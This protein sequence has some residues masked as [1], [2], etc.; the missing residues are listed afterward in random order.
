MLKIGRAHIWGEPGIRP[1]DR[2]P[3]LV[4]RSWIRPWI[5]PWIRL[6]IR[7]GETLQEQLLLRGTSREWRAGAAGQG[8]QDSC[9]G[10]DPASDPEDPMGTQDV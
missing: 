2:G 10:A 4:T 7:Q 9:Q 8:H 6:W 5:R 1:H 3:G